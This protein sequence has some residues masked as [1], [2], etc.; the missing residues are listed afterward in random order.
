MLELKQRSRRQKLFLPGTHTIRKWRCQKNEIANAE[1]SEDSDC[2]DHASSQTKID[3][4][5]ACQ[6]FPDTNTLVLNE[7]QCV[8]F[9]LQFCYLGTIIDFLLDGT[10]DIKCRIMKANK[11][12]GALS[13]IW[14]SNEVSLD[15]K[16]KLFLAM[17]V[18]FTLWNGETWAGN[19]TDLC[20]L[21]T[22]MHKTIRRIMKISMK[23]ACDEK[24]SNVMLRKGFGNLSPLSEIWR[25]RL[26]KFVGR[27]SRQ[28][29]N[30]LSR[31]FL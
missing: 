8:P 24:N 5:A 12:V 15:A 20:L 7:N 11:A 29:P 16:V 27:T 30:A 10:T 17:P 26:L 23:K 31:M 19:K 4:K 9:V 22:F 14:N 3:L 25:H 21:D 6:K 13:F 18:N 1:R 2:L 28:N